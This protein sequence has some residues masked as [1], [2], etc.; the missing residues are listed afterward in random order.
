MLSSK[1]QLFTEAWMTAATAASKLPRSSHPARWRNGRLSGT[2]W[3]ALSDITLLPEGERR[4]SM[5]IHVH[6]CSNLPT[7]NSP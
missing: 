6:A 7:M 2:A 4:V 5:F 3:N 1:P